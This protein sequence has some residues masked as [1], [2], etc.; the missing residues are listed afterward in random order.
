MTDTTTEAVERECR[1]I[2]DAITA[3]KIPARIGVR[4]QDMLRALTTERDT[5]TA[6]VN[7]LEDENARLRGILDDLFDEAQ[8]V[9]RDGGRKLARMV[10][11]AHS[12]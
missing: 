1:N 2:H 4:W 5:L 6:R 7:E 10:T 9:H 3:L 8:Q 11:D 12:T